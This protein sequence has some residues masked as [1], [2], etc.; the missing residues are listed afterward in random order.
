[1]RGFLCGFCHIWKVR[2][3]HVRQQQSS[4][5]RAHRGFQIHTWD[6]AIDYCQTL[7]VLTWFKTIMKVPFHASYT[8]FSLYLLPGNNCR[9][10]SKYV[11]LQC[12]RDMVSPKGVWT[13]RQN[14]IFVEHNVLN[15]VHILNI[16][17]YCFTFLFTFI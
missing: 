12:K 14:K 8:L 13:L 5:T 4:L 17:I 1:M 11:T 9:D 10:W 3:P 7:F 16:Y 6:F 15:D 2:W